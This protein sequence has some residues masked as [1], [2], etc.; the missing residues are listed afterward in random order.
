MSSEVWLP[1]VALVFGFGLRQVTEW[2]KHK[3]VLEQEARVWRR[4]LQ[5]DVIWEI[6]NLM[7]SAVEFSDSLYLARN[8]F[9]RNN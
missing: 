1:L 6:Q 3:R 2:M 9:D 8:R 4:D 7:A 5:R